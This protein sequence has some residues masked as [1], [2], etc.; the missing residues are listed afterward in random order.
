MPP[1]WVLPNQTPERVPA[2]WSFCLARISANLSS[3]TL[4]WFASPPVSVTMESKA[5]TSPRAVVSTMPF[6]S[7][8][9]TCASP[10]A[11]SRRRNG[12]SA[13]LAPVDSSFFWNFRS[14]RT[15]WFSNVFSPRS[16]VSPSLR[17]WN[18]MAWSD[19]R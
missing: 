9:T 15:I 4:Y 10:E 19:F 2:F 11:F 17:I 7:V 6:L 5:L 3:S 12:M 14:A 16:T 1:S 18:V 13:I 8:T